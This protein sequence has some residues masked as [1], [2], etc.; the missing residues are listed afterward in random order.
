MVLNIANGD[1][2]PS[3]GVDLAVNADDAIH[4]MRAEVARALFRL[5]QPH[6]HLAVAKIAEG[7]GI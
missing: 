7:V 4:V 6:P 1:W 2:H 3:R 5:Q